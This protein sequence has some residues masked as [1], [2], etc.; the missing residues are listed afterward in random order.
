MS[1]SKGGRVVRGAIAAVLLVLMALIGIVGSARAQANEALVRFVL[2][3]PDTP[4][5]DIWVDGGATFKGMKY[6]TATDLTSM[7]AGSHDIAIVPNDQDLDA[8]LL[9]TTID[10]EAGGAYEEAVVGTADSIDLQQYPIDLSP[11]TAG[12]VRIRMINAS[13]DAPALDVAVTDG[14]VIAS[15][16]S[17]PDAGDYTEVDAGS[18]SLTL[19]EAGTDTVAL[20]VNGLPLNDGLVYDVFAIGQVSASTLNVQV[21]TASPSTA[22]GGPTG[23]TGSTTGVASTGVGTTVSHGEGLGWLFVAA[24]LIL[25]VGG[26]V[27]RS[28]MSTR[29]R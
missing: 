8:A 7:P 2:T 28:S 3:S 23:E 19:T 29:G 9:Q 13:P 11:V 17:F 1:Q 21:L 6:D 25:A 10:L 18:T 27:A 12:K 15:D 24:A 14:T 22:V 4:A 26:Y 20:A 16:L 5:V